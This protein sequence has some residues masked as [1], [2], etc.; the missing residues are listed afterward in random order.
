MILP[1]VLAVNLWLISHEFLKSTMGK[2]L[3]L[4]KSIGSR[5]ISFIE[6]N[7]QA[8]DSIGQTLK[9]NLI[10]QFSYQLLVNFEYLIYKYIIEREI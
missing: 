3:H 2:A 7:V 6:S 1:M 4:L 9:F 10:L 5:Q 8:F